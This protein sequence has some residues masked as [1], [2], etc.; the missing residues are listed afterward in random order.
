MITSNQCHVITSPGAN[1]YCVPAALSALTGRHVSIVESP[2]RQHL[3]DLPITGVYLPIGLRVLSELGYK[4][5]DVLDDPDLTLN[6]FVRR[7]ASP[8]RNYLVEIP[9]HA[10]IVSARRIVD[11]HHH[12]GVAVELYGTRRSHVMRA[13]EV[14]QS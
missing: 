14:Y 2:I 1:I 6:Q 11:N 3:G 13:F 8:D 5:R 12:S 4:Y 9:G 7:V 10:L